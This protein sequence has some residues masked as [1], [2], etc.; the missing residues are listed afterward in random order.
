L[1]F[2]T[3][4]FGRIA[5][6]GKRR[7]LPRAGGAFECRHL[8]AARQNLLDGPVLAFVQMRVLVRDRGARALRHELGMLTLAGRSP[9][10][11]T[12]PSSQA[13]RLR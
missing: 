6:G 9:Q 7:R 2:V 3:V 10:R 8:I 5:N 4:T 11:A 1:D 13:P 12:G